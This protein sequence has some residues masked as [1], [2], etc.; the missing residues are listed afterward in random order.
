VVGE[1]LK[2]ES[3]LGVLFQIVQFKVWK[4]LTRTYRGSFLFLEAG[5]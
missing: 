5:K 2:P 3:D 1:L 4:S